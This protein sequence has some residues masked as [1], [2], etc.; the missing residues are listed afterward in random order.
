VP[1]API[2]LAATAVGGGQVDLSWTAVEPATH[3]SLSYGPSSGNYLYGVSN[4]GKVT[5]FAVGGLDPGAD[6]CFAVR[7][8]NDCAPSELSNEICT[9]V[10]GRVLGVT[11]LADTGDLVDDLYWLLV[12]IS[13]VCV[14]L[15]LRQLSAK[16][17]A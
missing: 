6:Y 15:G 10:A 13:A 17:S 1:S 11:T 16:K 2:L 9:G 12:I 8:V 14:G 4:M 7:A 5:S 3:Y